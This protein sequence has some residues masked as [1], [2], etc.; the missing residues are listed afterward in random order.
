MENAHAVADF[1]CHQVRTTR[2]RRPMWLKPRGMLV[3]SF[4]LDWE[5]VFRGLRWA[6]G[7]EFGLEGRPKNRKR[8]LSPLFH[9]YFAGC[10]R[11][12]HFGLGVEQIIGSVVVK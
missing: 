5:G 4:P 8:R 1:C 11:H 10:G 9:V 12:G 2:V 7:S 3:L 6:V